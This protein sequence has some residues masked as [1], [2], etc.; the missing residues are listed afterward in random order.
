M[1]HEKILNILCIVICVLFFSFVGFM[2]Y[3]IYQMRIDYEC[4]TM[5]WDEAKQIPQCQKYIIGGT[6]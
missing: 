4:N 5:P 2:A 3:E 6:K 1:K